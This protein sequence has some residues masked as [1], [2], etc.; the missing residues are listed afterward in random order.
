MSWEILKF[1]LRYHLR[2]PLFYI[3]FIIFF[4]MTFGAVTSDAVQI[5]GALGNV[6]RNAPFVIMQ[7]LLVMSTFGVLTTTAYVASAINRDFEYNTDSL[8]FS[9]PVKKRQYLF[10]RFTAAFIVS[11]LVYLG[12][13]TAIMV[14]SFMPWL[15]KERLGA[16]ALKPYVFSY[17]ILILP[18]LFLFAAIFFTVA[19]LTR[20]LMATYTSV[21]AFYVAYIVSRVSLRDLDSEKI[22]ILLDPFGFSPFARTTR[23]WTVFEKNNNLLPLDGVFL[24]NRLLWIGVALVLLGLTFVFFKMEVGSGS[25]KKKKKSAVNDAALVP[26]GVAIPHVSQRF[27]G[28]ASLRQYFTTIRVE[29]GAILKSLPFIVIMLLAVLNTVG[30]AV[31]AGPIFGTRFYPVTYE[32]LEVIEGNFFFFAVIIAAFYAGEIVWR[33]RM[34]KLNEVT[35][36]MPSPTWAIWAGKLTALCI[37]LYFTLFAAVL[38][39]IA[40]QATK[41]YHHF[42][43]GLYFRGAFLILGMKLLLVTILMFLGQIITNNRYVGFLIALFYIVAQ[44]VLDALHYQ[45]HLYQV[46]V[47]PDTTYSDMNGYGHFARPFEWF[48]LYWTFF[49]AILLIIGHLFWVRGTETA[50]R[51][52]SRVAR[53]RLGMP[54]VTM[55]A[56]FAIAFVSTGCFIFYNTNVLNH[57]STDDQRDKR[58]AET[59]KLYKKYDRIPQPR[60]TDVQ[61]NVDIYPE[62]R[63]VDIRGTYTLVNKTQQPIS[64][65]HVVM[66]PDVPLSV[67]IPGAT[68]AKN[69]ADHGYF[70]YHLAQPLAPGATIPMSFTVTIHHQGFENVSRDNTIVANGT[71]INNFATFPHLGYSPNVE[72]QETPKRRKYGLAPVV[73]AAKIDDPTARLDNGITRDADWINLDTTV[74]T[75]PDQIALAPGY[76][77]KEWTINGRRYF[78]YKTTSPILGFFAYLSAR[79]EVKR[80]TWKGIPI[81]IYYDPSH[82]YNVDRMIYGVQKSL[83]YFTTNFS[84]YQHKQVRILEFPRYAQFAQ[85]FPNTIP[86]SESIGFVADLRNK[87]DIDYVY[88]VTAHEVAH[89]W[90][91]HQ[92]IGADVQGGSMLAETLAQYS[93]LMVMEKEYGR[94]KMR[95]FLKYELDRY[96]AGRGGELVAEMPLMLVENQGYIHYRKGSLVMYELRDEIGEDKV[97]A[98]LRQLIHDH[99]FEQPPY[100]TTRALIADFRAVTPPE[101]QSLITD[102][103]ET[104]TLYDNKATSATVSKRPDGKYVVTV[105][106]ESKKFRADDRGKETATPVNDWVDIGVLGASKTK[107]NEPVLAL[108]KHHLTTPKATFSF[109]IAT[110]PDRAGIDPLNKLVD[111]NPDDNTKKVDVVEN[112]KAGS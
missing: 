4:F 31:F 101:K 35:D 28:M 94:D 68:L 5:G 11:S 25:G 59:E 22:G 7:L 6:N 82:A 37:T 14:G 88:Y 66:V 57:Y 83:D 50:M 63:W 106:V 69:D 34:L 56:L 92:V 26:A 46:F 64:D 2:Q 51:I 102:L 107:G 48:S 32:M 99:A 54:A 41:H 81:E 36:A 49:A 39:T 62:K 19:A 72:L 100:A 1:E 21:A 27:G 90:W 79:Y 75:S 70:I 112:A 30:G 111:R 3:L 98:A 23:Y 74:S 71:F 65:L 85:S 20:S 67:Q 87:E 13:V 38:T 10:G 45:H 95:R 76:L 18:N 105:T 24:G 47:L 8:F 97:N 86:F 29:T 44:V 93:A 91:A 53:G 109:V 73:R 96:L 43:L 15:D 110:K 78:R 33:E 42:E 108:E 16:F 12:V 80:S 55:L 103:F 61:A 84:P 104:I 60:I 89:Q 52:R 17:F 40:V 58:S 77:Q 9:S